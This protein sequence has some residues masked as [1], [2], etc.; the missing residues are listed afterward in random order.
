MTD[1]AGLLRD[2]Q[3]VGDDW[4]NY[5]PLKRPRKDSKSNSMTILSKD[6]SKADQAG[7]GTKTRT[8]R[9]SMKNAPLRKP[10]T[11][12]ASHLPVKADEL[13]A[14]FS[15]NTK[16]SKAHQASI[17]DKLLENKL[18]FS[19]DKKA[20]ISEGV[21]PSCQMPFSLLLL[22]SP[23]WHLTECFQVDRS[24]LHECP[25]GISC[26]STMASHYS[27]YNHYQL[28]RWRATGCA[29]EMPKAGE[30]SADS[31]ISL[32][33]ATESESDSYS[34]TVE[35]PESQPLQPN[36][37]ASRNCKNVNDSSCSDEL[38]EAEVLP[39]RSFSSPIKKDVGKTSVAEAALP[40]SRPRLRV[41]PKKLK[42]AVGS[43][44]TQKDIRSFFTS[45]ERP[46]PSITGHAVAVQAK[47]HG[48][49]STDA[50]TRPEWSVRW[51]EKKPSVG[52]VVSG[53]PSQNKES[54]V[55]RKAWGLSPEPHMT[56]GDYP[57]GSER[58]A[59]A[60]QCP[61]YK[62]IPGTAF[63]VDAFS[64]GTVP[65]I[66]AYFLS[67][68]HADHYQGLTRRFSMPIYCGKIT[69]NLVQLQIKV[70]KKYMNILPV[71][72]PVRV[73]GVE[74]TLLE[75]NHC[76]GA[77]MFLFSLANGRVYLHTGDFRAHKSMEIYPALMKASVDVLYLDTTYCNPRYDFAPQE[78][79]VE[80]AAALAKA[81]VLKDPKT[82]V[83][84]GA[85]TI[86]KEK[87]FVAIAKELKSK[88]CVLQP[89]LR[90]LK[91]LEDSE[92]L[93]LLTSTWED[94]SVH[95]LPMNRLSFQALEDHLNQFHGRFSKVLAIKPTGWEHRGG[96]KKPLSDIKPRRSTSGLIS[97]YGIPY[98]E[99]SSY[100][101]MQRFVQFLRPKSIL[102][103]VN[104]GKPQERAKMQA[105]FSSW[106]DA[107]S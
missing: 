7:V 32:S 3:D 62:K 107:G 25:H 59:A 48:G 66:S 45:P 8:V 91:C 69:A 92:I 79:T 37:T 105:I 80:F 73:Q 93:G 43:S 51:W 71:N 30:L 76:P 89:K 46:K 38:V 106:L 47:T 67:H 65:G 13:N 29:Q 14:I 72:E 33:L 57:T 31:G 61:F 103:T 98:S 15:E 60:R 5:K 86:G 12:R 24:K 81:H 58:G 64:Y 6:S 21:C 78:D 4:E 53:A 42:I 49:C 10:R 22:Q 27:R 2:V 54:R 100:Y 11:R 94:A 95:V 18:T 104:N 39:M 102:P 26:D 28:A 44:E 99:H 19:P 88:V 35:L 50:G 74:V 101:E 34:G 77:V 85:Y 36:S 55:K 9:R 20:K 56:D 84:C 16:S 97:V 82:L 63:T 87:I 68:F 52:P 70:D 23:N 83:V 41:L 90:I 1:S 17:D 40:G 75:A 96:A